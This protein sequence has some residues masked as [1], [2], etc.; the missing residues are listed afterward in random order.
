M[1]PDV[2]II[3]LT[4]KLWK[5]IFILFPIV[6]GSVVAANMPTIYLERV[7]FMISFV[8]QIFW[9]VTYIAFFDKVKKI[10]YEMV[11]KNG[12]SKVR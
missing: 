3:K 7:V 2:M 9:I 11:D 4:Y 5:W 12:L 8:V 1:K 10:K 6:V